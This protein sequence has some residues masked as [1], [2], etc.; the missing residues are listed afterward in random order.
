M[1]D[2]TTNSERVGFC[3]DCGKPLTKETVRAVG[4]GAFCEPCLQTRLTAAPGATQTAAQNTPG[5]QFVPPMPPIEKLP[6]PVLAGFLSIIP[7]VGQ[8]YNGQYAKGIAILLICAVLDSLGKTNHLGFLGV[9]AFGW[10]IYQIVDAYQ[11][12]KARVEGRPLP[13]PFELNDIGERLG[14]G[15]GFGTSAETRAAAYGRAPVAP[16]AYQASAATAQATTAAQATASTEWT[17]VNQN[18]APAANW[19]GYAPPMSA[20]YAPYAAPVPPTPY[21]ANPYNPTP[22]PNVPMPA[23][24]ASFPLV[25]IWLIGLG[26][27]F[28]LAEF[29][30]SWSLNG[31]TTTAIVLGAVAA[32]IFVR[33]LGYM[34][35]MSY[36]GSMLHMLRG[37]LILMVIAVLFLLQGVH[38]LTIG[39]TWPVFFIALG[40]VLLGERLGVGTQPY[41]Y[42]H[43]APVSV[44]PPAAAAQAATTSQQVSEQQISEHSDERDGYTR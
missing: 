41:P 9:V 20:S 35:G 22:M 12:A 37:P 5:A 27:L 31:P 3:Q 15:K 17:P 28:M 11:T 39:Q 25:A 30:P 18:P 7:G 43:A 34:G 10:W 26:V 2:E 36:Q 1:S 42:P 6:S 23:R 24:G 16:S 13:N 19:A 44:V 40:A 8:V 4:G 33:R 14:F 21:S 38:A 32:S 29:M